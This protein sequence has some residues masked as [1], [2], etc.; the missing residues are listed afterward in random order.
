MIVPDSDEPQAHS[1][2]RI[3]HDFLLPPVEQ[4]PAGENI[5]LDEVGVFRIALKQTMVDADELQRLRNAGR[6]VFLLGATN[7]KENIDPAV[8]SRF[9][10][11]IELPNPDPS[12]RQ[13]LFEI[14]LGKKPN[15]D[16]DPA[17]VAAELAAKSKGMSG[18]DIRNLAAY[19]V[20][21]ATR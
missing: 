13:R 6:H 9:G 1:T 3:G 19:Y 12:Q 20:V 7:H 18:R 16:F 17:A 21:T 2:N 11:Q 5:G 14:F 8:L 4:H 15:R 10:F